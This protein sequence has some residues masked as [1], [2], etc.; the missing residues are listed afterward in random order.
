MLLGTGNSFNISD[1]VGA[2]NVGKYS[3]ED[4]VC[5]PNI[6][7]SLFTT[8]HGIDVKNVAVIGHGFTKVSDFSLSYDNI[9]GNVTVTNMVIKAHADVRA[10]YTNIQK[11]LSQNVSITPK[12]YICVGRTGGVNPNPVIISN[13]SL[14]IG[15]TYSFGAYAA[16]SFPSNYAP[17]GCEVIVAKPV[18]ESAGY[19]ASYFI[20]KA[21][22]NTISSSAFYFTNGGEFIQLD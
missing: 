11:D 8:P 5:V 14:K 13:G 16:V 4:F 10:S 21:T 9:T 19:F 18:L 20:V 1:I 15:K 12:V 22:S 2:E 7:S 3:E 6:S 17:N